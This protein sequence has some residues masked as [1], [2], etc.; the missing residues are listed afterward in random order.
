MSELKHYGTPRHSGRYPWGSG[1]NPYQRDGNFLSYVKRMKDGGMTEN[2]IA[3]ALIGSSASV[4]DLHAKM[5]LVENEYKKERMDRAAKLRAKGY[6][7]EKIGEMMGESNSTISSWL[8]PNSDISY[9]SSTKK[10]RETGRYAWDDPKNPK[11]D[12]NFVNEVR[13]LKKEEGLS[14]AQVAKKLIGKD[15]TSSDLRAKYTVAVNRIREENKKKVF[16]LHEQG[17]GPTEIQRQTG[18]KE[19]TVRSWINGQDAPKPKSVEAICDILKKQVEEKKYIDVGSG[20]EQVLGIS[21]TKM[22]HALKYMK[23]LGYTVTDVQTDQMGTAEGMKTTIHVLAYPGATYRELKKNKAQIQSVQNYITDEAAKISDR[24]LPPVNSISSERIQVRYAEDGGTE[25]DG[26]I[27]LRRGL[28]DL[29]LG[30]ANYAQVRIGVDGTHYLKGVAVYSDNMPPGVDVIFNTN[31]TKDK[32]KLEVMKKME[33]NKDGS[34][35]E[36]NPFGASIKLTENLKR[37]PR[38]YTDENGVEKVSPI[39]V[40]YE[41]GDWSKWT[42]SIASQML[43][44]QP[45]QLIKTQLDLSYETKKTRLDT[46]S[47]LTNPVVKKKLL[48]EFASDCDSTAVHLDGDTVALIRYPHAGTFEIPILKVNNSNEYAQRTIGNGSVDA[49]GIPHSAAVQLS[50]ADFDGDSVLVIPVT[51]ATNI[52]ARKMLKELK[53]FDEI[54]EEKYEIKETDPRYKKYPFIIKGSSR[55]QT[56][57]GEASNLITDMTL[58]K[59]SDE[60]IA[61]AVKYSMVIIDAAKHHL[62]Y[63]QC[64]KDMDIQEL[65]NTYQKHP[66]GRKPGGAS[67]LISRAKH[68]VNNIPTRIPDKRKI[69]DGGTGNPMGWDPETGEVR[70]IPKPNDTY[71][72]RKKVMETVIDPETGKKKK[73]EKKVQYVDPVT[74]EITERNEWYNT[75]KIKQRTIQSTEMAE[76]N[77]AR[78]LISDFNT[79]EERAYAE[80]ANRLK[81]LANEARKEYLSTPVYR[82]DPEAAKIYK[83]EVESLNRKLKLALSNSPRERQAQLYADATVEA[84]KKALYPDKL[85]KKE[86]GRLRDQA[87]AAGRVRFGAKKE[88]VEFEEREWEAIQAGAIAPTTLKTLLKNAKAETVEKLATPR[89]TRGLSPAQEALAQRYRDRGYTVEEIAA[90]LNVSSSTISRLTTA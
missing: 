67:T 74:G 24:G 40:V 80:Y 47:S 49:V 5:S 16:E 44:K 78:T 38:Y 73:V 65:I 27:E 14:D 52:K 10:P 12:E 23:E 42:K 56:L 30:D 71:P 19:Q 89:T 64:F 32:T 11:R 83:A 90:T 34:I 75:G 3:K 57:M 55:E 20:V 8:K 88:P 4:S 59:A 62:D 72:E 48:E 1:E 29:N 54:K 36:A 61:R 66:D 81:S 2:E 86:L 7:V 63:K 13:R 26:I 41:E 79:P 15:A 9:G 28:R 87:L 70:Y 85:T 37:V 33:R 35:N 53:G 51:D 50:G 18:I 22:N 68:Q 58:K 45:I 82:K 76:T 77:D 6:S 31:K 84:Q 69:E 21:R 39:N 17:Y 43:S 60:E 25:K 46:I